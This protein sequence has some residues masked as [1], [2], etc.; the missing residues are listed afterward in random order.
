MSGR[1]NFVVESVFSGVETAGSTETARRKE[2][3]RILATQQL[4]R[5]YALARRLVGDDAEDA[6]QDTLLKAYRGFDRLEHRAAA[7]GWLTSILVNTCRDRG[8]ARSRRPDEVELDDVEEFSLYRKIADEDPFPYSDS[9]HLDFLQQF[10]REDVRAVL[11]ELPD[12]YRIPL[13]LVHVDGYATKE[14]A[15]MLEVPLGTILA[16]LHR[17]RKLFERTMWDYAERNGLLREVR[18]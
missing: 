1:N 4:P 17:G 14:V 9:L 6:V 7:P 10:G 8:R 5:L 2:E 11:A 15:R 18:T 12:H 16:R 13:V 3:F